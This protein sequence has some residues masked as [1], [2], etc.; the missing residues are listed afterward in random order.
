MRILVIDD[1]RSVQRTLELHLKEYGQIDFASNGQEAIE[2]VHIS[3][4]EEN[5]Y[6][7]ILLD[8][9]MPE[10]NGFNCLKMIRILEDVKGLSFDQT[11]KI[12]MV[13]VESH[14]DSIAAAFQDQC[15]G[16]IIKPVTKKVLLA[17]MKSLN[18]LENDNSMKLI[19]ECPQ[20]GHSAG[21]SVSN[22]NALVKCKNCGMEFS[23]L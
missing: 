10:V 1:D 23:A 3:F 5:Y 11:A 21:T 9:H 18:L 4:K 22:R 19:S 7:L 15:E 17:Q 13:T 8:I 16:Y 12:V 20:C 2:K 14:S 6:S